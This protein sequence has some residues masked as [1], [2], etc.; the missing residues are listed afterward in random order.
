M[1]KFSTTSRAILETCDSQI[2]EVMDEAIKYFDFK[3]LSGKRGREEQDNLFRLG[4][5]MKKYPGSKHNTEPLSEA[6][7]IAPYPVNWK[8]E[9]RFRY[10]AGW[11][12]AIA[13]VKGIRLRWGGDW[14]MDTEVMD[15]TFM[16]LGHFEIFKR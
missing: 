9:A 7:D 2:V 1:P 3:I 16:D 14:D 10:L 8:D 15:Q 12:M 11:I 4:L 13:R 5:S 6:I